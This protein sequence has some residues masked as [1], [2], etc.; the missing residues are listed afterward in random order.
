VACGEVRYYDG[1]DVRPRFARPALAIRNTTKGRS[2]SPFR[3]LTLGNV[4]ITI[5]AEPALIGDGQ[6]CRERMPARTVVPTGSDTEWDS[7]VRG[8]WVGELT[9][10][11]GKNTRESNFRFAGTRPD[12][13]DTAVQFT[14]NSDNA[15]QSSVDS[16][17]T[18]RFIDAPLGFGAGPGRIVPRDEN[19]LPIIYCV[20]VTI[21]AGH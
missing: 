18:L 17:T 3:N 20:N 19:G 10:W 13:P 1:T 21:T 2:K 7:R 5:G 15:E 16:T 12:D 4:R 11:Q 14:S 6:L 8:E 9:I